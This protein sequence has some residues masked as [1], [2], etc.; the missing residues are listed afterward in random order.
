MI[1]SLVV[2]AVSLLIGAIG[3]YAGAKVIVDSEDYT[4]ALVTALLG[5]II[6]GV[7]GFFFGWIP[8]LGPLLVFVAYLAIINARY[9]GGWVD[10]AA[11]TIVAWLSVLIVLYV[12]ALV[13]VTGFDA[14]G[15]PGV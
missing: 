11:I 15:V 4:Y 3:I 5:A 8:L 10:A 1:E 6:W 2:F 13:G 9:P 12:L 7:V 14:V